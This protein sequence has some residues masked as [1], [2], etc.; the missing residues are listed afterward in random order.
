LILARK[1][2]RPNI[3]ANYLLDL[4]HAFNKFYSSCQVLH[5]D[6]LLKKKRLLI[7]K[8]YIITLI[9]ASELLGIKIPEKM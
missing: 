7:T 9:N 6:D 1:D 2:Y 5:S 8:C 4:S 3:I